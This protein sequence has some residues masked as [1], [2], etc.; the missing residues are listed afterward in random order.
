MSAWRGSAGAGSGRSV[1]SRDGYAAGEGGNNPRSAP[2]PRRS[3]GKV[4]RA[5]G[6]IVNRGGAWEGAVILSPPH[7]REV[8]CWMH[9]AACIQSRLIGVVSGRGADRHGAGV[10][11]SSIHPDPGSKLP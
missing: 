10:G 4:G 11:S 9:H 1:R 5:D 7:D 6:S 3:S 2:G 8:W